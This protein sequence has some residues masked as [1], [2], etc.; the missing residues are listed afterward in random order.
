MHFSTFILFA[1]VCCVVPCSRPSGAGHCQYTSSTCSGSFISGYGPGAA[2]YKCCVPESSSSATGL[3][4]L[5]ILGTPPSSCWSCAA[6]SYKVVALGGYQQAC[7]SVDI[8]S[9][10]LRPLTTAGWT[11]RFQ[12]CGELQCSGERRNLQDRRIHMFPCTRTQTIGVA[13]LSPTKFLAVIDNK[14]MK[15]GRL[16]FDIEPTPGTCNAWNLATFRNMAL[17]IEAMEFAAA[18]KRTQ[19]GIYANRK[20][21]CLL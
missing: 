17:A 20:V 12:P 15:L 21:L 10:S 9:R 3:A 7:G 13:C 14:A 18:R 11:S 19:V 16:W 6:P 8:T 4:G 1:G 5:D 2:D